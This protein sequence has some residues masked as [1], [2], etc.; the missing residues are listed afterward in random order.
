MTE[1]FKVKEI[2]G[3]GLGCIAT[4]DIKMGTVIMRETPQLQISLANEA[5][6][7]VCCPESVLGLLASYNCMSKL[8]QTEYL[9][10]YDKFDNLHVLPLEQKLELKNC[11]EERSFHLIRLPFLNLFSRRTLRSL[12][13]YSPE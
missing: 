1:L 11:L 10:L 9:N 3:R 8:D 6:K 7:I 13:P 5:G 12:V 4:K 2:D